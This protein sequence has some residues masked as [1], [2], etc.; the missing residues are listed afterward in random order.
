MNPHKVIWQEGMLLRPQHFQQNDRHYDYQMR[1]RTQLANSYAWGFLVLDIDH[2]QLSSGKVVINEAR[3]VLPDGSLF[4]LAGGEHSLVLE[5]P[6]NTGNTPVYLGL[7]LMTGNYIEARRHDQPDVLARYKAYSTEVS[8]SNAGETL[9]TFISCA[10]PDVRLLLGEETHD[11]VFAK[12]KVCQVRSTTADSAI[13]LDQRYTPTFIHAGASSYLQGCLKEVISML[14][15]RGNAIAQRIRSSG[16][17]AGAEVGDF[18]MLQLI[19]RTELVLRHYLTLQHLHPE[20][21]YCALLSMLG[22]LAT[23]G[24]ESKRVQLDSVYQHSDQGASFRALMTAIRQAL[25]MV[26]EQHAVEL[27]L[28]QRGK[29][30]RVAPRADE[31]LADTFVL[32]ASADCDPEELRKKLPDHMKIGPV[33]NIDFM[34][35]SHIGGIVLRPLPVAPRQIAFHAKKT[36][37]I[38]DFNSRQ[39]DEIVQSGG[40]GFH[41]AV[42]LPGL[43][44]QLWAIRN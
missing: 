13:G 41:V 10:R 30:V 8:D 40:L 14:A 29:N 22:D 23:F 21:L 5:V 35:T 17:V 39:Q 7:P 26:L 27:E 43:E 42:D 34:V 15:L 1:Q 25:S 2:Q 16:S 38:L 37:F 11:Q 12:I 28:Q 6:A 9:S 3:G 31:F 20:A 32:A 24:S 19:N 44:L 36:Y 4:D 33:E 18:M